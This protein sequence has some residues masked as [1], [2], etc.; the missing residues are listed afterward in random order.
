LAASD[1]LFQSARVSVLLDHEL[2]SK[3]NSHLKERLHHAQIL[4]YISNIIFLLAS[5]FFP[6]KF[7]VPNN[8][9]NR[10]HFFKV[11]NEFNFNLVLDD[12]DDDYNHD[13][14]LDYY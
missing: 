14:D 2:S 9:S 3:R 11:I 1:E 10:D 12:D 8:Y 7:I 13:D 6:V 4:T 5:V